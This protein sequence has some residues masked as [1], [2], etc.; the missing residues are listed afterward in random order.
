VGAQILGDDLPQEVRARRRFGGVLRC[1]SHQNLFM[2]KKWTSGI[3]TGGVEGVTGRYARGMAR[4][5]R[6]PHPARL[7]GVQPDGERSIFPQYLW[8]IVCISCKFGG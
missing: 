4:M 8:I 2:N 5:P 3:L 6:V 7:C 1:S